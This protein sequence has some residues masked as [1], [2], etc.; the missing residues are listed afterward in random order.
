MTDIVDVIDIGPSVPRRRNRFWKLVGSSIL[1]AWGWHLN[2]HFPD[3]PRQV[4]IAAPHTS[5]WDLVFG[6][7]A[8]LAVELDLRWYAK[9]TLFVGVWDRFFRAIGGLPVDRRAPGGV[10]AQIAREFRESPHRLIALTPEGTRSPVGHWKRGFYHIAL[11]AQA[12]VTVGYID[13]AKK[14]VGTTFTFV[15]TGDWDSDMAPVFEFYRTVT[16]KK[17]ENY[18]ADPR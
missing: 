8:A 17:P 4:T 9:H 18:V 5:N 13:Y 11:A 1:R 15:P 10:V 14:E 7:A 16:P 6:I 12:P 3:E 2:F